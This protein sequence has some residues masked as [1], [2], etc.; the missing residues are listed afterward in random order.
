MKT[1]NHFPIPAVSKIFSGLTADQA[2]EILSAIGAVTVSYDRGEAI[3]KQWT[4]ATHHYLVVSGEVHSYYDHTNGR[5]SVNGVFR[6]G[7]SF[8]LV[9]AFSDLH[10]NPSNAVAISESVVIKMP[11]V[12]IINNDLLIETIARRKFIQNAVNIMSQS[13]FNARLRSFILEQ[14][15]LEY[16]VITYLNELSKH[17]NSCDFDIPFDR[18]EL[19]DYLVCDRTSLCT[20]LSKMK[21]K[22]LI[23]FSKNHFW[24]CVPFE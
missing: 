8:G 14:P 18:Q 15:S 21:A 12:D 23:D 2:K 4:K 19:A 10:E 3:I 13:A 6:H 22:G 1:L 20:T 7:D 9:F 5:R 11:L 17:T 24:I 16:R